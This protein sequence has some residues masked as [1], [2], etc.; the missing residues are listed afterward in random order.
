MLKRA[1]QFVV[2]AVLMVTSACSEQHTSDPSTSDTTDALATP[3]PPGMTISNPHLAT[4][5]SRTLN[6]M[7]AAVAGT[8]SVVYIS[9]EPGTFPTAT[10]VL[11]RNTVTQNVIHAAIIDGGFDPVAIAGDA[12]DLLELTIER[13]EDPH[14][15]YVKVPPRKPPNIVRTSPSKG[16]IDVA[17]NTMIEIVFSEPVNPNTLTSSSIRV[18]RGSVQVVGQ[19]ELASNGLSAQFH[20]LEGLLGGTAYEIHVTPDVRDAD[21]DRLDADYTIN[22]TTE[23]CA[24]YAIPTSCPPFPTGGMSTVTGVVREWTPSGLKPVAGALVYGW[25]QGSTF[26]YATGAVQT[27]ADGRYVHQSIPNLKLL[28]TVFKE[29]HTQ[30]CAM[31]ADITGS[32]DP[33][34]L[35]IVSN[36]NLMMQATTAKPRISG[37]IYEMINGVRIPVSGAWVYFDAFDD[38]VAAS[39]YSSV[40]GTYALCRLTSIGW[41]QGIYAGKPG[42]E[43]AYTHMDLLPGADTKFDIELKRQ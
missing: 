33:I 34:D 25:V 10:G 35:E 5:V 23:G 40:D 27:D 43:W 28:L 1:L 31:L 2:P 29:G 32:D 13:P 38:L 16:R 15:I 9:I 11:I 39:V 6:P 4:S 18:M 22:F 30:P 21:G 8:D 12:G 36:D 37:T 3:P 14:V 26:G 17:L 41:G 20:S 7:S 42:Y 24:G 19:I